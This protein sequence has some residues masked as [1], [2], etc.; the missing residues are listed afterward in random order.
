MG[1]TGGPQPKDLADKAEYEYTTTRRQRKNNNKG[2]RER[3]FHR[4]PI[5]E[6]NGESSDSILP[7]DWIEAA[8]PD[9]GRKYFY[10]S[11][12]GKVSWDRPAWP[13]YR[14]RFQQATATGKYHLAVD[15]TPYHEE[16]NDEQDVAK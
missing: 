8:D 7:D 5:A 4:D 16:S 15:E 6:T 14:R 3:R 11:A 10:N 1:A 12:T 13:K 2:R 9:S